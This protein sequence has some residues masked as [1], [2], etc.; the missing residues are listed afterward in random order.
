MLSRLGELLREFGCD[1][2]RAGGGSRGANASEAEA[3][4]G[5]VAG[6]LTE[7][8]WEEGGGGLGDNECEVMRFLTLDKRP[9][10]SEEAVEVVPAWE[11]SVEDME[12]MLESLRLALLLALNMAEAS[13]GAMGGRAGCMVVGVVA[14]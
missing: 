14:L 13:A 2:G 3:T 9:L 5:I 8:L 11:T 12:K 4:V 1:S 10:D 7:I 6:V